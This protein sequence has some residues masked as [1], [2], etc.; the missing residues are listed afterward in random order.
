M[1]VAGWSVLLAYV[2]ARAVTVPWLARRVRRRTLLAAAA[3]LWSV[4]PAGRALRGD[5]GGLLSAALELAGM[6]LLVTAFLVASSLLAVDAVTLGGL[7]LRRL[8]PRLRGVALLAGLA[9][10]AVALVQGLRPP[11]VQRYEVVLPRLPGALDGTRV[12]ALSDLHLGSLLGERWLAARVAQVE[13]LRP[14][15][16]VLVGDVLEGHGANPA[17]FVPGLSRLWARFGRFAVTGNHENHGGRGTATAAF[18]EA[19][20]TV[21]RDRWAEA[22]PGLV[23]A[24]VD[25]YRRSGG[26]EEGTRAVERALAERPPGAVVLLSHHP[27]NAPAAAAAGAGLTISGHT[28]G[29]QVWPFGLLVGRVT[30]FVA[31]RYEV[32][33][34]TLLVGRGTGVWGARMRLWRRGEI[35]LVVLRSPALASEAPR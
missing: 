22:A 6:H 12:A 16:V 33:R 7:V 20:F 26:G 9:L 13:A 11:A 19:G 10:A 8:A 27:G 4:L 3:A 29:G 17:R 32:G 34:M 31:G 23:F 25:D 21:L 14:D 28:H 2:A 5:E 35:L 1:L 24:G 18:E 30:P 15:F